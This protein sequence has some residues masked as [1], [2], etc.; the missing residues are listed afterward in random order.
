MSK[1]MRL[2]KGD[3]VVVR[4]GQFKGKKGE[5]SE[6]LRS[7]NRVIVKGVNVVKRHLRPSAAHPEGFYEKELSIHASN[8][9]HIDPDSQKATRVGVEFTDGKKELIAKKSGKKIR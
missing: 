9:A 3:Q 6:V 1:K 5:I 7:L 4:T 2:K 8:V